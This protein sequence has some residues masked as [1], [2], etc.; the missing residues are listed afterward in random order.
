MS[1]DIDFEDMAFFTG[2]VLGD[3][4]NDELKI[5]RDALGVSEQINK[6]VNWAVANFQKIAICYG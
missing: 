3:F 5:V 6:S 1:L 4:T 2:S